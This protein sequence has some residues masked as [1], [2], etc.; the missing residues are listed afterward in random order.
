MEGVA[1][2]SD[3]DAHLVPQH[4]Q[5]GSGNRQAI[6]REKVQVPIG[7]D[8]L[9]TYCVLGSARRVHISVHLITFIGVCN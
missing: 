2:W 8:I 7:F 5:V 3:S 6:F 9:R 1:L 4:R